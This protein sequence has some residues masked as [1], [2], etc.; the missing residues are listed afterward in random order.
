V[1][2]DFERI[3]KRGAV[4]NKYQ[5]PKRVQLHNYHEKKTNKLQEIPGIGLLS[6][7]HL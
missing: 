6:T 2:Q 1:Q 7:V 4:I 5:A 3:K